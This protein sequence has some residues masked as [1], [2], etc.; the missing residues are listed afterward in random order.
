MQESLPLSPSLLYGLAAL[1]T[2]GGAVLLWL[3]PRLNP[4]RR[5]EGAAAW[6]GVV[7]GS[8]VT[9]S[10][11]ALGVL[12]Y[13]RQQQP[14]LVQP[15]GAVGRPAPALT[16]RLVETDEPRTLA[17]YR[18]QVILLNLWATW[19]GPCLAEIP[20]LNRFQQAYRDQGVVVIMISDE[21]RQTVLEFMKERPLEPVS[22]YLPP[23]TRWPWPYNRVEQARPTTFVIDRQGIIRETW[24]GAA[25]FA[26]FEA[27][28]LP[29]LE[30]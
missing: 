23:G 1:L 9:L 17:D 5:L 8:F 12:A 19:C 16:F 29:Y 4:H 11:L 28:V 26:Q 13:L 6:T 3:A 22:G 27:A 25:D 7:L 14:E 2:L 24:P 10:G 20:E 30:Q 21:P 18:G 15:P